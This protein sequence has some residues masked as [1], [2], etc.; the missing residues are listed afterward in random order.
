MGVLLLLA[1]LVAT[2]AFT[3]GVHLG[4]RVVPKPLVEHQAPE[5]RSVET[6]VDSVPSRHELQE[7]T[8]AANQG[9][10]ETLSQSLHD[11]V[12]RTGIK[13]DS[14]RQV[15]LPSG[16]RKGAPD[17]KPAATEPGKELAALSIAEVA[18]SRRVPPEGRFTLQI[19]SYPSIR[20]AKDQVDSMEALGLQP[21]LRVAE[22]KGKG[23]WFRVY[24][25]GFSSRDDAEKAGEG[26][27]SQ[28][29]IDSFIVAKMID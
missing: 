28:H 8:K 3:L 29:V 15:D 9:L 7:L 23:K 6:T 26:Y 21:V 27:R 17:A 16:T 22:I 18:A 1:V 4:K 12:A 11:E 2:F 25:G 24:L 19:G 10:D 5:A 13:L 14:P 20:E